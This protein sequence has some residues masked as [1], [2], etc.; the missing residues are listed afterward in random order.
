[1]SS[2]NADIERVESPFKAGKH[3][4]AKEELTLTA[5]NLKTAE[6]EQITLDTKQFF[7]VKYDSPSGK[8]LVSTDTHAFAVSKD[9]VRII[10][11]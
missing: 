9:K 3:L 4:V 1:M 8:L 5:L 10:E 7:T 2:N 11:D 6:A